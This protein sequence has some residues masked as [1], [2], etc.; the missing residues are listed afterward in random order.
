[1]LEKSQPRM[2]FDQPLSF[3]GSSYVFLEAELLSVNKKVDILS[4]LCFV[5]F[6]RIPSASFCAAC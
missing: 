5:V 4:H 3:P 6:V 2:T 1:M